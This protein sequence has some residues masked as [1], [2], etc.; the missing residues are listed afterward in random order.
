MSLRQLAERAGM[1][2]ASL[3][4]MERRE[5]EGSITL[6][7][8]DKLAK[9]MDADVYYFVVP[10]RPL[11]DMVRTRAEAMARR[12]AKEVAETMALEGQTTSPDRLEQLVDHHTE[13]LLRNEGSLWDDA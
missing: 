12:L 11:E 1:T 13:R 7:S 9:A 5:A 2:K 3:S 6:N 10:R 4:Q 8:I